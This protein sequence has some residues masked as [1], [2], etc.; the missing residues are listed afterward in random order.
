MEIVTAFVPASSMNWQ[1][2]FC[3]TFETIL[4]W[5]IILISH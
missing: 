1:A 4:H 2:R 5:H 3:P